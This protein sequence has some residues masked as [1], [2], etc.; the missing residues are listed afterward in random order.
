VEGEEVMPI[1]TL[2][3]GCDVIVPV[4]TGRIVCPKCGRK[5]KR[6]G[7]EVPAKR[8]PEHGIQK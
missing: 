8:N 5:A 2:T 1:Y 3:C 6:A 7:Q 4:G